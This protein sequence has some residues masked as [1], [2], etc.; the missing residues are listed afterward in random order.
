MIVCISLLS[1]RSETHSR[2]RFGQSRRRP[3]TRESHCRIFR[4][5]LVKQIL[6]V[7]QL[8]KHEWDILVRLRIARIK[9]QIKRES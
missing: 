2:N 8:N 6:P 1:C 9:F 3:H 5:T 4:T 7:R